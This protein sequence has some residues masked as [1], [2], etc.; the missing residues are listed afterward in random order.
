MS[1]LAQAKNLIGALQTHQRFIECVTAPS[2]DSPLQSLDSK[3]YILT[4]N[5]IEL[6]FHDVSGVEVDDANR[7]FFLVWKFFLTEA[8]RRAEPELPDAS[9]SYN[10]S[11]VM[12]HSTVKLAPMIKFLDAMSTPLQ[13]PVSPA[14]AAQA[15]L[16]A[17]EV[18]SKAF[19]LILDY[20][21]HVWGFSLR[22]PGRAMFKHVLI[23]QVLCEMDSLA[24]EWVAIARP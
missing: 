10:V 23:T 8:L 24:N 16:A 18:G 9:G 12:W 11:I 21:D 20:A 3:D 5:V 22:A 14:S 6:F 7:R 15:A 2:P 13:L 1:P 19:Q 4:P 17:A